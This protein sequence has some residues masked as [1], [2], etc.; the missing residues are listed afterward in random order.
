MSI[1]VFDIET[2]PD[3]ELGKKI[4][5]LSTNEA[6]DIA[7]IMIYK[8]SEKSGTHKTFLPHFLHKIVAISV[9][10]HKDQELKLWTLG[11]EN[12][13]EKKILENFFEGINKFVPQIVSWNGVNFDLPVIQHRAL[14]L[15]VVG[16]QYWENGRNNQSFK[17]NN[18]LSKYHERH[19][20]VMDTLASFSK[21]AYCSLQNMALSIGL[22]GKLGMDG[23]MVWEKFLTKD[24]KS[25]RN[26]CEIDVLNT[27]LIYLRFEMIRGNISND[28]Y[29]NKINIVKQMLESSSNQ[30]WNIYFNEWTK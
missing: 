16:E 6:K 13:S 23:S 10:F 9:L 24:I 28:T 25:I 5:N 18:Y 21:P 4:Y 2:V 1:L 15:G 30:H 17:W 14:T 8:N 20:D 27:F 19:L 7:K 11:R 3:T 22:P 12:D 26:Y 29:I